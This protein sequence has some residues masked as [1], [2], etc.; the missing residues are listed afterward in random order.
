MIDWNDPKSK[1]SKYFTV[2]EALW[3][4]ELNRLAGLPEDDLTDEKKANLQKTFAWMDKVREWIGKPIK[5]TIAF[6]SLSYHLDLYRRINEKRKAQ[7]QPEL[8]VPMKSSHLFGNAVD[9]VVI[10][11][12]CDSVRQKI[13]DE[14]KLEE[15]NLRM[16]DN[17]KGANWVHLDDRAVG[18]GG[19]FF[20]P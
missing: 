4:S 17:G 10:G 18:P 9:F 20:K 5:V 13:L 11:M 12:D 14:K 1:I 15:W 19:R 16:E 6:R 2:K 3:L 7:G 8:R